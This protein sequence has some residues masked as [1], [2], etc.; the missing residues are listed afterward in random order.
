MGSNMQ[1]LSS[2][3]MWLKL[4][5]G[6]LLSVGLMS[7]CATMP[8]QPPTFANL[9]KF[10]Q[11][12]LNTAIFR[13][14]FIGDPNMSQGTAEEI[15]LVKAAKTTLDAGYRYF[16][17]LNESK[18]P[19][20]RRTVVYP[21]TFYNSPWYG[22]PYGGSYRSR[23]PFYDSQFRNSP[24]YNQGWGWND[25]YYQSTVYNL[26]PVDVSYTIKCS[27]TSSADNEE[28]DATLIM[29]SLGAKYYLNAGGSPRMI[30]QETQKAAK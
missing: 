15:A 17:V 7:G 16:Y 6:S 22:S 2:H 23:S 27:N 10:E 11:Y 25:P 24:F 12:Q 5:S 14:R 20:T 19:Q 13:I 28:F 8:K 1:K 3:T 9:G 30:P 4:L 18:V 21:N 29:S 26:D